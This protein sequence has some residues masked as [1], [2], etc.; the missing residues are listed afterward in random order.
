MYCILRE[1][2]ELSPVYHV[3]ISFESM[4]RTCEAAP[5]DGDGVGEGG[6]GEREGYI[7]IEH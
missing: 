6:G 5:E 2:T 1:P 3:H 4:K 7:Y